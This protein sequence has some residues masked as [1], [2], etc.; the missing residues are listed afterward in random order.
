MYFI[1]VAGSCLPSQF[2]CDDGTCIAAHW[3]CDSYKDCE[4]GSDEP[5]ECGE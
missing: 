5:S 4:D 3:K 2:R 1:I